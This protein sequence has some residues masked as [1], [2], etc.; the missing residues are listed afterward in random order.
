M[1]QLKKR[2]KGEEQGLK[3]EMS[4]RISEGMME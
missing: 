1:T 2:E 4:E 3:R